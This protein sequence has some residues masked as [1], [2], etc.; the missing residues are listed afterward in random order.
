MLNHDSK[1][2]PHHLDAS[3]RF[4]LGDPAATVTRH[5]QNPDIWGLQNLTSAKWVTTTEDGVVHDVL[6]GRSVTLA[7]GTRI[8]FGTC[9]GEIRL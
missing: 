4:E 6:P 2:Y 1:L 3:R 9:E 8:Q 5:P 7:T